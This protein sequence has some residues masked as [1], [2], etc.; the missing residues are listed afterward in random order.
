MTQ[1]RKTLPLYTKIEQFDID[2][3]R[4]EFSI[5][6][7]LD[8]SLN[9]DQLNFSNSAEDQKMLH[10]I[11]TQKR[12]KYSKWFDF[13]TY[14]NLYILRFND[15]FDFPEHNMKNI[16]HTQIFKQEVKDTFKGTYI[17]QVI[18][19]IKAQYTKIDKA[20]L[21][22]LDPHTELKYHIDFDTAKISKVHIPILTSPDS[23]FKWIKDKREIRQHFE[24]DGAAWWLNIGIPHGVDNNADTHRFHLIVEVYI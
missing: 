5:R 14:S 17:E 10:Y 16:Y 9:F 24:A 8:P 6:G 21:A 18:N 4:N 23:E 20:Y 3:L 12:E 22:R 2:K 15:Q 7:Y 13:S 19:R 1:S 11:Q